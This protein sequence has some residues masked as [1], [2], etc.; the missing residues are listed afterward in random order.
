LLLRDN[1]GK[2]H[3]FNAV[4]DTGFDGS[5]CVNL[6]IAKL[7]N[8]EL[9]GIT[10]TI[11][12]DNIAIK[13]QVYKA[14]VQFPELDLEYVEFNTLTITKVSQKEELIIGSKLLD[15][16]GRANKVS[17]TFNYHDQE[18]FWTEI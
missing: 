10:S 8:L 17:I 18:I 16:F 1:N 2:F 13:N 9:V 14:Q 7:L 5:L 12:A 4:V 11:N 6:T 15:V 3:K